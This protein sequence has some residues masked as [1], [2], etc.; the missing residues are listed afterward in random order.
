MSKMLFFQGGT[1][2]LSDTGEQEQVPAP[3]QWVKGRWRCEGYHYA[4]LLPWLRT[5]HIRDLVPRWKTLALPLH[6][7]REP[8]APLAIAPHL[9]DELTRLCAHYLL[10]A[11]HGK[12]PLDPVA[13]FHLANGARLQRLNWLLDR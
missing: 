3:F 12:A 2:V 13:R 11:K 10:H 7:R 8:H 1:L 6:D 9:R 4:S 5:Q